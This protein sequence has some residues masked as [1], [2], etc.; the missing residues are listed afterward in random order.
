MKLLIVFG[1]R[2]EAIK[3]APLVKELQQ[4]AALDVKVCVTAQHR[5]MLDQV[6]QLFE[7]TPDFDLDLM[8]PGQTLSV[9]VAGESALELGEVKVVKN[10]KA[11]STPK[12]PRILPSSP[13]KKAPNFEPQYS[14]NFGADS[15]GR[16]HTGGRQ[17]SPGRAMRLESPG[18]GSGSARPASPRSASPRPDSPGRKAKPASPKPRQASPMSRLFGGSKGKK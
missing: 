5:Q 9:A 17:D 11:R 15:P 6:L 8:R 16:A 12:P 3:M 18:R 13:A 4:S 10:G 14:I 1:T 7:I 2:P